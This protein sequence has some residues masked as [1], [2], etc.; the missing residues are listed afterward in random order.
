[1]LH[2]YLL[3][4]T[5]I[6][7]ARAKDDKAAFTCVVCTKRPE[8]A[9]HTRSRKE[10]VRGIGTWLSFR[11]FLCHARNQPSFHA[12]SMLASAPRSEQN[13]LT[14]SLPGQGDDKMK[15]GSVCDYFLFGY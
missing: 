3:E 14:N 7:I 5:I 1:M 6:M 12:Q 9:W 2:K 11:D 8:L 4:M 15:Q 10:S 13:Q